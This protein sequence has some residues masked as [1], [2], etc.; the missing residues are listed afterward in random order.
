MK[1]LSRRDL[2][3]TGMVGFSALSAGG[4]WLPEYA[5][6]QMAPFAF[7]KGRQS[8]SIAHQQTQSLTGLSSGTRTV[9][10]MSIGAA[11]ANRIV[12]VGI[13]H[14][15]SRSSGVSNLTVGGIT[16]TQRATVTNASGSILYFWTAAVP[17]GTTANIVFSLGGTCDSLGVSIFR[18]TG[19]SS[20]VP[21]STSSS[22]A[23]PGVTNISMPIGS[24]AIG[25]SMSG[26][27]SGPP[28]AA[29]TN[30]QE[31]FEQRPSGQNTT[32]SGAINQTS[33]GS[34]TVSCD[35]SNTT[36]GGRATLTA[37]WV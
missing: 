7:F 4:V 33:S 32:F 14:N 16:A 37:A 23:D 15:D 8:V 25:I 9:S 2:I 36:S 29:W 27:A 35:W 22:I 11:A 31:Q 3:K 24:F 30:A 18:A 34:I 6:A 19:L 1:K 20:A 13:L 5:K 12:I 10:G 21:T 26:S 17:S 28:T